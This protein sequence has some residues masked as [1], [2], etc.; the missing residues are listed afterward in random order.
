MNFA[1]TNTNAELTQAA[2]SLIDF[3]SQYNVLANFD[4]TAT[5]DFC[6]T[7]AAAGVARRLTELLEAHPE[8]DGS[9]QMLGIAADYIGSLVDDLFLFSYVQDIEPEILDGLVASYRVICSRLN[10]DV[11][12]VLAGHLKDRKAFGEAL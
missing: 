8:I 12:E 5:H 2:L 4:S 11:D 6:E 9:F 10:R 1:T 3:V 7:R